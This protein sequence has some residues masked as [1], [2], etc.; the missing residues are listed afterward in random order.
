MTVIFDCLNVMPY[1][2]ARNG[3]IMLNFNTR[4]HFVSLCTTCMHVKSVRM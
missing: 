3:R 1:D 2:K 4:V